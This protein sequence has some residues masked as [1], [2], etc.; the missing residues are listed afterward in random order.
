MHGIKLLEKLFNKKHFKIQKGGDKETS[1]LIK[2]VIVVI[3]LFFVYTYFQNKEKD[4]NKIERHMI[5]NNSNSFLSNALSSRDNGTNNIGVEKV[6]SNCNNNNIG[7]NVNNDNSQMEIIRPPPSMAVGQDLYGVLRN[8]DYKTYNDPLT[9]PFKR[10]DYMIPAH[11]VDPNRFGLYTRGGPTAF[12]KMGFLSNPNAQPGD[13]YKFLTLMGRQKYYN[14]T[15][16]EYYIVSTNRDENIK[17]DLDKKRELFTGD[18]VTVSQLNNVE[19]DV[20]IDKNL[21]YEYSPY[22]V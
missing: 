19:Y 4:V 7:D 2:L 11:V 9:P 20:N 22:I 1:A 17:F 14:S 3:I 15:Q 10:D 5:S 13:T 12:K 18:K 21:D 8:Y 6:Y 16:Y